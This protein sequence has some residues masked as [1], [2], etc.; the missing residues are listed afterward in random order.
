MNRKEI[1]KEIYNTAIEAGFTVKQY[2]R[3]DLV[4]QPKT[5]E[6]VAVAIKLMEKYS[7]IGFLDGWRFNLS[8]RRF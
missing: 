2:S 5:D 4:L 1:V 8:I 6:Q 7:D 3:H